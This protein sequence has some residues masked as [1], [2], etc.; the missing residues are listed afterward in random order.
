MHDLPVLLVT[1]GSKGAQIDQPRRAGLP[2]RPA[3]TGPGA[4]HHRR[5]DWPEVQAARS[6]LPAELGEPLP[7]LRFC[8][9]MGAALA[10]ADLAVSRAG[11]STLG[12]YPLFGL[13]AILVPYPYAWRYQ[14]VNAD[15]LARP[16]RGHVARQMR[17]CQPACCPPSWICWHSPRDLQAMRQAMRRWP[18]RTLPRKSP[19]LAAPDW[20]SAQRQAPLM[21]SLDVIF[22][23][24]VVL[25]AIIG[26]MRGW[27]KELLVTFAV[28]L[29]LFIITVLENYVP[30]VTKMVMDSTCPA[31]IRRRFSGCAPCC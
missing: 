24:F 5:L 1:G 17:I 8:T 14:K 6:D 18:A 2:A 12:E 9:K 25:F 3:A 15:Y 27:A 30:F 23:M 28:I 7:S 10:A 22:W 13:P 4:A 19:D 11:A 29:A 16:R 20:R 26:L 21:I 31:A